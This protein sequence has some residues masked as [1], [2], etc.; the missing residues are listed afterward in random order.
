[1][2]YANFNGFDDDEQDG[3]VLGTVLVVAVVLFLIGFVV[4]S[5]VRGGAS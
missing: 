3:R 2:S 1:M 4:W 5:W